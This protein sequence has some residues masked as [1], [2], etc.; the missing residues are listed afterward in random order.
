MSQHFV[1]LVSRSTDAR[2]RLLTMGSATLMS[3]LPK[4]VEG[5]GDD[6]SIEALVY[7]LT[8]WA[9][10]VSACDLLIQSKGW[11]WAEV[12]PKGKDF[13]TFKVG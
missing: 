6:A 11:G 5:C 12:L 8:D 13:C 4:L 3:M 2:D 10:V 7:F 1:G 9:Q